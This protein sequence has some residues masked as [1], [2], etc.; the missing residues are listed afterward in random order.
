MTFIN[1]FKRKSFIA[2]AAV[3]IALLS[4]VVTPT[5]VYAE[6]VDANG[7][8]TFGND[9][10][11]QINFKDNVTITDLATGRFYRA[12]HPG[13]NLEDGDNDAEYIYFLVDPATQ[14][15][16]TTPTASGKC[17]GAIMLDEDGRDNG[18]PDGPAI[19]LV[20]TTL[21]GGE[22]VMAA[23]GGSL[24]NNSLSDWTGNVKDK[25]GRDS[26]RISSSSVLGVTTPGSIITADGE[27]GQEKTC[28][29]E[30]LDLGWI[31]CPLLSLADL[32]IAELDETIINT[33]A[34]P[35]KY[36]ENN[37]SIPDEPADKLEATWARLRNIAYVILVP[38]MLVMVI[39]TALGFEFV[40]AYT[41]KRAFPRLAAA[42]IF[43]ALSWDI[44]KFLVV[45]TNNIG[46]GLGGLITS[47]FGIGMD[48]RLTDAF[49]PDGVGEN[50]AGGFTG[51]VIIGAGLALGSIGILLSY[52]FVATVALLVAFFLLSLRQ[53]LILFLMILAP[54]AILAWIFPGNDKLWKLW[55]GSFSKL[56]LLFPLI[57]LMIASG[58]A[59]A[60]VVQDVESNIF[61]TLIKLAAYIGPYFFIPAAFK[62]AGGAFAT[63]AGMAQDR[64]RGLF[65]RNKKYRQ[66]KMGSN[67][68]KTKA[69]N[70][71]QERRGLGWAA[72]GFNRGGVGL[73]TGAKGNFGFGERGRQAID[74]T[75]RNAMTD[76]MKS[77]EFQGIANN[78]DALMAAT[79]TSARE[80]QEALTARFGDSDRATRAVR[81][82]QASTGFGRPQA[83]A[84]A[85]QLVTTGTGYDNLQDMT[86]TL[87]RASGG[88]S[89][90]ASALAGFA[91]AETKKVG[92]FDLAPSYGV[93][94]DLVQRQAQTP[95]A[96]GAAPTAADYGAGLR[97]SWNSA[98]LY[99]LAS[100]KTTAMRQYADHFTDQL[101]HGNADQRRDA[102]IAMMEMQNM[103]PN[104]TGDNQIVI[105]NAMQ[106]MRDYAGTQLGL[107]FDANSSVEDQIAAIVNTGPLASQPQGPQGQALTGQTIRGQART[108]DRE[109]SNNQGRGVI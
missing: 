45:L 79:Y 63:V 96:G 70:R 39:S 46:S 84:S 47:A 32:G 77:S 69:G 103:L 9:I 93:L 37:E 68:S 109:S 48:Y 100:G 58:K 41:F 28:E 85:Q 74:Q 52:A 10:L 31:L 22:C 73:G 71:F 50:F 61:G 1:L 35:N 44:T 15:P 3:A 29:S 104:A 107:N 17:P 14:Q 26:L 56:L 21:S 42:V 13:F 80:A 86:Q 51:L 102:A 2:A 83:I 59:F 12:V 8:E 67:W 30:G 33:L 65:D 49:T 87:A 5:R 89:N 90:T 38:I 16:I 64:E 19:R 20:E 108:Y 82:V 101:Q 27:G 43:I 92:R 34:V 40:S 55:W 23:S 36:F 76:I 95:L 57:V 11:G 91:N 99:S 81:A 62:F 105:N 94:N 78:D 7:V 24:P 6:W 54:L 4:I 18:G 72:R 88:N 60:S 25:D 53:M 97:S 98:G 66:E 106:Q 75:R